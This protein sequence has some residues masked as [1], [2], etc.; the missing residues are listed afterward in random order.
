MKDAKGHTYDFRVGI[1]TI[2]FA[3]ARRKGGP[4]GEGCDQSTETDRAAS[5]KVWKNSFIP[6][7]QFAPP[8]IHP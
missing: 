4:K 8:I 1:V 5:S 3:K 6:A 2:A 7:I